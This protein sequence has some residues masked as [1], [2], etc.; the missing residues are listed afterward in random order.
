MSSSKQF[1]ISV[2]NSR[3]LLIKDYTLVERAK[4]DANIYSLSEEFCIYG[5]QFRFG[6]CSTT[7]LLGFYITQRK[8]SKQSIN[9]ISFQNVKSGKFE[10]NASKK[11]FG[12]G[13]KLAPDEQC[14]TSWVVVPRPVIMD[15]ASPVSFTIELEHELP[16]FVD[17]LKQPSIG[18]LVQRSIAHT[19]KAN[20]GL[21]VTFMVNNQEVKAIK[22]ILRSISRVFQTMFDGEW[23]ETENNKI[24]IVGFSFNAMKVFIEMLHGVDHD[25]M[26]D[27][28]LGL[29]LI[30]L[31]DKYEVKEL[32]DWFANQVSKKVTVDNVIGVL[33]LGLQLNLIELKT[34]AISLIRTRPVG[35]LEQLSGYKSMSLDSAIVIMNALY[36]H[37][38]D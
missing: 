2:L 23:K 38:S 33:E 14:Y 37:K 17:S 30:L 15:L 27:V 12:K 25:M 21:D 6:N 24:E 34:P 13:T 35:K 18:N 10:L 4:S 11:Q 19:Y 3:T 5:W 32:V 26:D 22:L 29:E 7:S 31:A 9:Y 8:S 16:L 20:D 1:D 28:S 36:E